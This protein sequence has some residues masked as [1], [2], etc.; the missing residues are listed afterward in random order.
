MKAIPSKLAKPL[1]LCAFTLWALLPAVP[2][3]AANEVINWS[4]QYI[5]D[6]STAANLNVGTATTITGG[7]IWAYRDNV[8]KS[9]TS[10]YDTAAASAKFY[11]VIQI[12]SGSGTTGSPTFRVNN[13][14][15]FDVLRLQTQSSAG[16][17]PSVQLRGMLFWKKEDFLG[18]Y[19]AAPALSLDSLSNFTSNISFIQ[20]N[21]EARFAVQSNG[22]WYLSQ[23]SFAKSTGASGGAGDLFVLDNLG[24]SLWAEWDLDSA[25]APLNPV[26]LSFDIA[27]SSLGDITAV[28]LYFSSEITGGGRRSAFE[29]STMQVTAI[30][31][32]R[33]TVLTGTGA[34]LG[35]GWLLL[36]RKPG[37]R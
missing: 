25:T 23:A 17:T 36:R 13:G 18:G 28:G 9:P 2:L 11:G 21:A 5:N 22:Q 14:V 20:G 7:Q 1:A 24:T 10:H 31:E 8:A 3:K 6:S 4:G 26:P 35:L 16:D 12:T 33:S 30:P 34:A 15:D 32:A 37:V 27:A 29:F 19:S